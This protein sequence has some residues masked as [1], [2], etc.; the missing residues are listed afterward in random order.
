MCSSDHSNMLLLPWWHHP[1]PA[2][3]M[4]Q[5]KD[6]AHATGVGALDPLDPLIIWLMI[7]SDV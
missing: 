4:L 2:K 3:S 1:V 6:T 7:L 5:R